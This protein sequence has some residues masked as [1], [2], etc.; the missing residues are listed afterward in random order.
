MRPAAVAGWP[1]SP[2][3]DTFPL[4][5]PLN[6][7]PLCRHSD[8]PV[9]L[10]AQQQ[11]VRAER[12]GPAAPRWRCSGQRALDGCWCCHY[13]R[14]ALPV[15]RQPAGRLPLS[16]PAIFCSKELISAAAGA[17]GPPVVPQKQ[18]RHPEGKASPPTPAAGC[19]LAAAGAG[20]WV[21]WWPPRPS[22]PVPLHRGGN[23]LV[24]LNVSIV[25]GVLWHF[26]L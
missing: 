26:Q 19:L 10:Y 5:P 12:G 3:G 20:G 9:L 1:S 11:A 22:P 7:P 6:L 23:K 21:S 14:A 16:S 4:L 8:E 18:H 15:P 2:E 13:T 24:R 25:T 17:D